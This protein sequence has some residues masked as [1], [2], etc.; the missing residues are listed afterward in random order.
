MKLF[1]VLTVA[2]LVVSGGSLAGNWFLYQKYQAE[3][4]AADELESHLVQLEE[5]NQ[6]LQKQASRTA[7]LEQELA[8][9]RDQIKGYV[10]QRDSLKK[11]L[12]AAFAETAVLR[13]QIQTLES[14]KQSL[15]DRVTGVQVTEQ[16]VT[17]E[18]QKIA[19]L[20]PATSLNGSKGS[21]KQQPAGIA[22][23]AS[24]RP[25][26]ASPMEKESGESGPFAPLPA[27]GESAADQRPLQILS[28]NRQFKFVVI[29]GG[30]RGKIKIGDTLRVEQNGKLIGRIQVEKLYENFSACNIVEEIPPAEIREGD[31]VRLA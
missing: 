18:A 16:A 21:V 8:R 30:I 10:G 3:L 7:G 19:G 27:A 28:V 9:L 13:R 4:T 5:Q 25:V 12:D 22:A 15:Q 11:E 1:R 17:L 24:S 29:N 14:E 31:L 23:K 26:P 20:P 6:S 2:A